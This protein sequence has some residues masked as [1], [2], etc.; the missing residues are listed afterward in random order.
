MKASTSW[1]HHPMVATSTSSMTA[2]GQ[3]IAVSLSAR[4]RGCPVQ[5]RRVGFHGSRT[6]AWLL[7]EFLQEY[8]LD[9]RSKR[10]D[11]TPLESDA[12]SE[13]WN[14]DAHQCHYHLVHKLV[15]PCAC[16]SNNK[17]SPIQS[18]EPVYLE[19]DP[20]PI[21]IRNVKRFAYEEMLASLCGRESLFKVWCCLI[22]GR[23]H[24]WRVAPI[25]TRN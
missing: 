22:W 17:A 21:R 20:A 3:V 11:F 1:C 6:L 18:L 4:R 24:M 13:P 9:A 2:D 8:V 7:G 10:N 12:I 16:T 19:Q 14:T 15:A 25:M 5:G 23:N